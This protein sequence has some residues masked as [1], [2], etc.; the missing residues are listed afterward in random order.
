MVI[1]VTY[2]FNFLLFAVIFSLPV[3]FILFL[4]VRTHLRKRHLLIY[5]KIGFLDAPE[6]SANLSSNFHKFLKC[7]EYLELHDE[8]LNKLCPLCWVAGNLLTVSII[9]F[10]VTRI[11]LEILDAPPALLGG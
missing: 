1:S 10:V 11:A 6:D 5:D 8:V 9:L 2:F 4:Y 3:Y 7:K